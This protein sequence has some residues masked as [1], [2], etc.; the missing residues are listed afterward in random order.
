MAF[1][2]MK[3]YN[4][5]AKLYWW[6]VTSIGYL[7]LV[8]A[9]VGVLRMPAEMLLQVVIGST[10]AAVVGLFPVRIPGAKTSIAGAEIF[11]FLMLVLYG[12]AA[13]ILAAA[14][15]GFVASVRTSRRWTSRIGT[16]AMASLAMLL[17]A[18]AFIEARSHIETNGSGSAVLLICLIG[19]SILYFIANT[20][21]T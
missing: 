2:D 16:P 4:P 17:C 13:A 7:A 5:A 6:A 10:I 14:L 21:L 19:F 18:T 9:I 12:P 8:F 20:L 1:I 3:D 11:I 15:E